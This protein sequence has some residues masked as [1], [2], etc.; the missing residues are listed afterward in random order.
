MLINTRNYLNDIKFSSNNDSTSKN[1]SIYVFFFCL[2]QSLLIIFFYLF[3]YF[4]II[5][6]RRS[7]QAPR[8]LPFGGVEKENMGLRASMREKRKTLAFIIIVFSSAVAA[9]TFSGSHLFHLGPP[10]SSSI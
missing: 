10:S 5:I 8:Y 9:L 7:K 4:M 6:S 3:T 2:L 1:I